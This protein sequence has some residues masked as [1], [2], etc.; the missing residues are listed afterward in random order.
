MPPTHFAWLYASEV[1][2]QLEHMFVARYEKISMQQILEKVK[3]I[4]CMKESYSREIVYLEEP[5]LSWPELD[6]EN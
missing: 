2:E 3:R 4:V 1:R 5:Q 6:W